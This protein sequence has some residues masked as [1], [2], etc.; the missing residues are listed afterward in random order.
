MPA[1]VLIRMSSAVTDA[2]HQRVVDRLVELVRVDPEPHRQRALRVEVDE[3]HLP[4]ELSQ[5]G[6]EV[7]RRVVLPTP[8]FWLHS[9]MTTAG[10][11]SVSGLG[12]RSFGRGRPVGPIS[13]GG[14]A[15][16]S[17][18][19]DISSSR[20]SVTPIPRF[21]GKQLQRRIGNLVRITA[22]SGNRTAKR[23]LVSPIGRR[24]CDVA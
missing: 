4:P 2:F 17:T 5:R 21:L 10:P 13:R 9:A 19:V 11:C 1:L 15:R 8:P 18:D 12:S 14:R 22:G 6:A 16:V 3:Q 23:A 20:E 7:D 24:G